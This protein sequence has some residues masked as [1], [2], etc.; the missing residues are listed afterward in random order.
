M[1]SGIKAERL[2]EL[3]ANESYGAWSGAE[4]SAFL[5]ESHLPLRL[6]F[7]SRKGPII[8]PLWFAYNSGC[9]ICCSP[10]ESML[11]TSLQAN[12]DVAFD[13]STNDLPYRGV[14]G[15][16]RASCSNAADNTR[17]EQLL[18]R[19]LGNAEGQLAQWLLNRTESESVITIEPEWLTSWDFTQRMQDLPK[20][21]ERL[22]DSAL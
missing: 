7:Q 18:T 5:A 13:V 21:A 2:V 6:S 11:V 19:Y 20:I 3:N 22:P 17:L 1:Q 16:G 8:V 9:L 14:R 10:T 12:P 4:I 15:R